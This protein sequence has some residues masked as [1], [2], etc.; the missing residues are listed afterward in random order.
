MRLSD[1]MYHSYCNCT[2]DYCEAGKYFAVHI[3]FLDSFVVSMVQSFERKILRK[4]FGPR[5]AKRVLRI[6]YSEE[7]YTLI[8]G[9]SLSKLH[10]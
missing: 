9:V 4:I 5:Q 3:T 7:V 1:R 6:G 8:N 2:K 10:T